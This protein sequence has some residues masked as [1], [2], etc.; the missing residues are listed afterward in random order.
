MVRQRMSNDVPAFPF[1]IGG[2][3]MGALMRSLDWSGS[4]LGTPE[5]WPAPFRMTV[6]LMLGSAFPMFVAWGPTLGFLYNDAYMD[7][8][9]GKHPDALGRPF[10]AIWAEIWTDIEPLIRRAMSGEATFVEDLP[11]RMRRKGFEEDTWFTFSYSPVRDEDGVVRGMF[12]AC[13][14]TTARVRAQEPTCGNGR[15]S[16]GN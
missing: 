4:P 10:H 12:C 16:C 2:G 8:L 5:T 13:T 7:V 3:A 6:S 9:G 14:E 15:T 11:L 1:L